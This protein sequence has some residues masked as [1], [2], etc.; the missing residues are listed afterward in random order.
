VEIKQQLE[1][2][3]AHVEAI[4][5]PDPRASV[6]DRRIKPIDSPSGQ[7]QSIQ[8]A[9]AQPLG[10]FTDV[11]LWTSATSMDIP[12][13]IHNGYVCF[14]VITDTL[15]PGDL[16]VTFAAVLEGAA[17]S[18][19]CELDRQ[20]LPSVYRGPGDYRIPL[21]RNDAAFARMTRVRLYMTSTNA[22]R[23]IEFRVAGELVSGPN[24]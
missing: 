18:S 17:G 15:A 5:R 16:A 9:I 19:F 22:V 23:T 14:T 4:Y 12:F 20:G 8:M 1:R 24:I 21:L 3:E 7:S 11:P 2:I 6:A 13:I 10:G